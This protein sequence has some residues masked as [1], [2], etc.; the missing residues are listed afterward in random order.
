MEKLVQDIAGLDYFSFS[1]NC[2]KKVI[3]RV[4]F[5]YDCDRSNPV[6]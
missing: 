2:N 4:G 5:F 6:F 1:G 3:G